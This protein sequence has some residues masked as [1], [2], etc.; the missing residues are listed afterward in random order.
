MDVRR[1]GQMAS[2]LNHSRLAQTAL[3]GTKLGS[4]ISRFSNAVEKHA[5]V[6]AD[7]VEQVKE[8]KAGGVSRS[9]LARTEGS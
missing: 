7:A 8:F 2:R 3:G 1:I 4:T 5:P 9:D 6:V